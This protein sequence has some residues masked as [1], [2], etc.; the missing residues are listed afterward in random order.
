MVYRRRTTRPRRRFVRRRMGRAVRRSRLF[1]TGSRRRDVTYTTQSTRGTRPVYFKS[2]RFNARAFR[3][4]LVTDTRFKSHYRSYGVVLGTVNSAA[5]STLLNISNIALLTNG[6]AP[7]WQSTGGAQPIDIGTSVPAFDGDIIVR[8][9]K[10]MFNA[11]N[12]T[13]KILKVHVW[14][15]WTQNRPTF[16]NI[17][18]TALASFDPTTVGDFSHQVGRVMK[19]EM[20]IL[21]PGEGFNWERRLRPQ[22]MDQ[23]EYIAQGSLPHILMGVQNLTDNTIN[24]VRVQTSWN[25]SFS[26]DAI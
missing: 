2:K 18:T 7:F 13:E 24:G 14:Y 12:T 5:D 10:W 1:A 16:S 17:P 9:G 19:A 15:Y 23:A 25:L 11:I 21:K 6:I 20:Y 4:Q 8:G 26:A 3:R 22:K